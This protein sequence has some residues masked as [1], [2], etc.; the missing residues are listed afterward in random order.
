ML[1][2]VSATLS[3]LNLTGVV[4]GKCTD[5]YHHR[6]THAQVGRK[7]HPCEVQTVGKVFEAAY[8]GHGY[9]S[10]IAGIDFEGHAVAGYDG[11]G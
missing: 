8:V 3:L 11:L 5:V 7:R 9:A 10:K 2:T 4:E 6:E 1:G